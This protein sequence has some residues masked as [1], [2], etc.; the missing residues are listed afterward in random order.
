MTDGADAGRA[1]ANLDQLSFSV[2]TTDISLAYV[3]QQ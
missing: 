2:N 3:T 1:F